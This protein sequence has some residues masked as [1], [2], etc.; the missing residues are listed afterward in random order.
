MTIIFIQIDKTGDDI[1]NQGYS[2]IV[3]KNLKKIYYY[4]I[5]NKIKEK[6]IGEFHQGV[7]NIDTTSKTKSKLR[8][9]IRFHTACAILIIKEIIKGQEKKEDIALNVCND[10]DSH[11]HEIKE[12]LYSNLTKY[13]PKIKREKINRAK[14]SRDSSISVASRNIF[15]K[16]KKETKNYKHINLDIQELRNI[17][18]KKKKR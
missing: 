4:R 6:L 10:F 3:A 7:F 13:I 5:P 8:F 16:R 18:E 2:V 17:I 9:K 12:M 1:L 15:N 11:I 14:F